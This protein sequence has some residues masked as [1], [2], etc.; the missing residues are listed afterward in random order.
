MHFPKTIENRCVLY[1]VFSEVHAS[2]IDEFKKNPAVVDIYDYGVDSN[3]YHLVM[4]RYKYSLKEWRVSQKK[5]LR[6]NLSLYLSLYKD[7]LK[8]I[9]QLHS[10][11]ITHYDIK[12]DNVF[13]DVIN[14]ERNPLDFSESNFNVAI[15]DL[16]ECKMFISNEDE[17]CEKNRGTEVIMSPEMLMLAI[18]IRKDTE[19]YDRRKRM[20]TNRLSDIWS[21]GCLFFELLTGE[22]LFQPHELFKLYTDSDELIEKEKFE[23]LDNNVYLIDFLK[24]IL[25][26]DPHFRPSISAVIKRFEHVHALL[27]ATGSSQLRVSS[28]KPYMTEATMLKS[29]EESQFLLQLE[30][31]KRLNSHSSDKKNSNEQQIAVKSIMPITEDIFYCSK[32]YLR[33]ERNLASMNITHI[34]SLASKGKFR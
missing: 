25:I 7:V 30:H 15:G 22:I 23:L 21:L 16:G 33:T 26:K 27:V 8:A 9:E 17:F 28:N 14:P 12:A 20:G 13:L 19:K 11:N 2:T 32:H 5:S 24:F 3:G 10:N 31:E 4:K 1:D 34:V 18:N 6:E 29:L